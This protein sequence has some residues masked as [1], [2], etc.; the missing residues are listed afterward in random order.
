MMWRVR[1]PARTPE[2][3]Y[4]RCISRVRDHEL[5]AR[6]ESVAGDVHAAS[7]QYEQSALTGALSAVPTQ[8]AV[9]AVSRKEMSD[10]YTL[11]LAKAKAPGRIVYDEIISAV[12]NGRCPLCGHR[13][14]ASLDHFLPSSL[15][16]SLSVTPLNLVPACSDCNKAKRD[17]APAGAEDVTM[18]PYF[19]DVEDEPWLAADVVQT[20]PASLVFS[21]SA[22]AGWD[23][24]LTTRVEHHFAKFRLAPLYASQAAEELSNIRYDL[25]NVHDAE[26]E[27]GV[28]SHLSAMAASREQAHRNSWQT[29]TY[30]ALSASQWFCDE[31]FR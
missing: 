3:T 16:P 27:T 5:K 28:K 29:A 2:W 31:G 17:H 1:Q 14:V 6:L 8:S 13:D 21:V 4:A 23:A 18:H 30:K 26:G 9:G 11:R 12:T 15:Y 22:P 20:A 24:I 7:H 10:V 25:S 19:D